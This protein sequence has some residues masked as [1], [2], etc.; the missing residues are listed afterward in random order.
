MR[1]LAADLTE[2]AQAKDQQRVALLCSQLELNLNPF[3]RE[4]QALV[5]AARIL[6]DP[7]K[8]DDHTREFGVR[9]TLLLKHDWDRAKREAQPWFFRGNEPR[10]VPYCEHL[11]GKPAATS[12]ATVAGKN[13]ILV[14]Y[15]TTLSFSS[16][17]IF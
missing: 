12:S 10:R 7:V 4:D 8:L 2:A 14:W 13:G 15:F 1:S 9:M 5:I 16:G 11:C 3:D 6:S 17:I